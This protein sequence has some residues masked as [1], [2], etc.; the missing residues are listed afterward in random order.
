MIPKKHTVSVPCSLGSVEIIPT[1]SWTFAMRYLIAAV[2]S[3]VVAFIGS[4][5]YVAS[6]VRGPHSY[7]IAKAAPLAIIYC[8]FFAFGFVSLIANLI[9]ALGYGRKKIPHAILPIAISVLICLGAIHKKR[10]S[11]AHSK[12]YREREAAT[13][14]AGAATND[15]ESFLPIIE[16]YCR[17]SPKSM[18]PVN[19]NQAIIAGLL[20]NTNT[21][22]ELLEKLAVGL[23]VRHEY[24]A[25]AALHPNCTTNVLKHLLN[26]P[27]LEDVL[28]N[29]RAVTPDLVN[30]L[31]TSTNYLTRARVARHPLIS[32]ESLEKLA[33]DPN[34]T[35]RYG[36]IANPKTSERLLDQ[37]GEDPDPTLQWNLRDRRKADVRNRAKEALDP[38]RREP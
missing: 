18:Y 16:D 23:D 4:F 37:L 5:V 12:A 29:S 25:Q 2:V 9:V 22:A 11:D 20:M 35:V 24:V 38:L 30:S 28:L 14:S 26:V 19:P 33:R 27:Q 34:L 8:T 21:P 10:F 36:V 6:F 3:L 17:T 31:V 1:K 15:F 13:A 7:G 32:S